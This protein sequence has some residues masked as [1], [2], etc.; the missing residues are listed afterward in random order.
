MKKTILTL[1]IA[2]MITSS[3]AACGSG[4][5]NE[6]DTSDPATSGVEDTTTAEPT[7]DDLFK[8]EKTD[9]GKTITIL[10]TETHSYEFDAAELNG[11]RV[12]DAVY[13]RNLDCE[14]W[15]G[16]SLNFVY[17]PGDYA[18]RE[19]LNQTV[20]DSVMAGDKEFDIVNGMVSCIM[21]LS[22]EG[23]FHNLYDIPDLDLDNPWWVSDMQEDLT[24]K[25]K[26]FGTIG[27]TS[28]SMY[29]GMYVIFANM[30][31]LDQFGADNIYDT[32]KSGKWTLDTLNDMVSKYYNDLNGDG[33]ISVDDDVVAMSV[34]EI[35][36][37]SMQASL[38]I[39]MIDI[40]K[41][42]TPVVAPLSDRTVLAID[43]LRKIFTQNSVEIQDTADMAKCFPEDRAV[44][45]MGKLEAVDGF[46]NMDSDFAI[47]PFPKL[48]ENQEKFLSCLSTASHIT[49]VPLTV[50]DTSA[51]GKTLE[52]MAY[53]SRRDVVPEYVDVFLKK[54]V[55]RDDSTK[56]MI[57]IIRNGSVLP[58]D[59]AY[60]TAV[61]ANATWTDNRP[62]WPNRI[63]STCG[64]YG[65]DY[66]ST[67][68]ENKA[69]WEGGIQTLLDSYAKID[70]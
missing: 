61:G 57:D 27:D 64:A 62:A 36:Y 38:G 40:D 50:E 59:Y 23:L 2:A 58:F 60:S 47:I 48:D 39:D 12:N 45:Y 10:G 8:V 14:S 11:D 3:L 5:T 65:W 15:L 22:T 26:L 1:L 20:R 37:H 24:I 6:N 51:V 56:E 53:L 30:N 52:T 31:L 54:K 25:G 41:S 33:S 67:I 9:L 44:F 21:P 4:N 16:I 69:A 35:V 7:E 66:A 32:V 18:N 70:S 63:V 49:F 68:A 19:V 55:A 42:G 46:R 29:K 28:L 17:K 13:N 43:K 34:H